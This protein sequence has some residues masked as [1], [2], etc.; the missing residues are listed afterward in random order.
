[1]DFWKLIQIDLRLKKLAEDFDLN[2]LMT[3]KAVQD[4]DSNQ[5]TT[6]KKLSVEFCKK[7]YLL[8][9]VTKLDIGYGH[10]GA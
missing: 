4:F 8:K 3:Q 5:L 2:Q 9:V 1:M 6:K 7:N 10:P